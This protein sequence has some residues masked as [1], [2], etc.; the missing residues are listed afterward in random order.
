MPRL[1]PS[2]G[3]QSDARM[4][5][6]VVRLIRSLT[7]RFSHGLEALAN[8]A[9]TFF[10]NIVMRYKLSEY[11]T[12]YRAFSR[13]VLESLP[14]EENSDDFIFD[15]EMLA[16]VIHFGFSIAEISCP[17]IHSPESS[18]ISFRRSVRYGLG[19]LATGLRVRLK[20]WKLAR[21]RFLHPTGRKLEFTP[22][23]RQ[24]HSQPERET[25]EEP[26]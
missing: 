23:S 24:R 13:Q 5:G 7:Y 8:R 2:L 14:L 19:V 26:A 20:K 25:V 4:T 11:H 16:Q 18:S 22:E 9:L 1:G 12:G 3:P 6:M 17:T 10:Q 15:N 21:P